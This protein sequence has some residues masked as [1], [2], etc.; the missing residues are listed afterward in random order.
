[1]KVKY[2]N[3]VQIAA[4]LIFTLLL[5][6]RRIVEPVTFGEYFVTNSTTKTLLINAVRIGGTEAILLANSISA[7]EKEHIFSFAEGSGGAVVPSNAFSS[8]IVYSENKSPTNIIYSKVE[9]SDW[10]Y[11]GLDREGHLV[12][13]LII[14]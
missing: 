9:N 1:M 5:N 11:E 4:L 2:I 12:Y 7:G 10:I 8:F 14:K 6:C 3:T 13:H